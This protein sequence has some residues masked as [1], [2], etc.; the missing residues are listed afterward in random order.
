MIVYRVHHESA[1]ND[2][3]YYS[4]HSWELNRSCKKRPLPKCDGINQELHQNML[5]GFN[6]LQQF[7]NWFYDKTEL[8][9]LADRGFNLY[10]YE[11]FDPYVSV[12]NGNTQI[13]FDK[14]DFKLIDRLN[15]LY[16]YENT[17]TKIYA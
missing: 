17:R 5:F 13:A 12:L 2:G 3:P 6:S 1:V 4:S 16:R 8:S 14:Y 11:S 7:E 15:L 10:V 9:I